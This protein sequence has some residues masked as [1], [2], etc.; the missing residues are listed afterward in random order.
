MRENEMREH[1]AFMQIPL[2][3]RSALL[4]GTHELLLIPAFVSLQ[5]VGG[6]KYVR[7]QW[8]PFEEPTDNIVCN[9]FEDGF[10]LGYS[11]VNHERKSFVIPPSAGTTAYQWGVLR[12]TMQEALERD[13]KTYG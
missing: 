5:E 3:W 1:I 4:A 12:D 6:S 8:F 11:I 7:Y 9:I 10:I 2:E 13:G